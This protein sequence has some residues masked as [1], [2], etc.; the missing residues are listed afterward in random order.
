MSFSSNQRPQTVGETQQKEIFFD[1]L[2]IQCVIHE[3]LLTLDTDIN[4]SRENSYYTLF[5]LISMLYLKSEYEW[6]KC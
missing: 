2:M 5:H 1:M 6:R 4:F 3:V